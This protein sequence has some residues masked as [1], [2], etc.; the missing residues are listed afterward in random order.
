MCYSDMEINHSA[1]KLT[2]LTDKASQQLTDKS[3]QQSA[4]ASAQPLS[5]N[6]V[7]RRASLDI[8]TVT[9]R[10]LLADVS[11]TSFV[12]LERRVAITNLG[13]G[14]DKTHLLQDDAIARV[15]HQI[16]EY[17]SVINSYKTPEH[18]AIPITAVATS[19]A[20]DAQNSDV[21]VERLRAL[22][23]ELSIIEGTREAALSF[24][25]AAQGHEGENLLVVDIGGGST[26]IVLGVGGGSP[27][28]SHSFNIGCRRMTE[29]FMACDPPTTE[30]CDALR[31]YV[32]EEMKPYFEQARAEGNT[33]D[34]IIAVAGTPTSVVAIDKHLEVY[35]SSKVHNTQVGR[36]TLERIYD[37][38]RAMDLEHR[39]QVIGLEPARA[40]V[41]VAGLAILLEVLTLTNCSSFTVSESDILQ[42][43][44]LSD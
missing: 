43:M 3:A 39:K 21:L 36:E 18:P 41:I 34:R 31:A 16:A 37:E 32:Y 13:I 4:D 20:R 10:L 5:G 38:L 26:E 27:R 28:F 24:R 17:V 44:L 6:L 9:C 29:R 35:D 19:A 2:Q 15:E 42:G 7:Q 30:Q 22:G 11:D 23:V 40:G 8:G 14:V 33:I 12:E 1:G 25:G